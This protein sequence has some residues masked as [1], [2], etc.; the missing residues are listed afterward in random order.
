MSNQGRKNVGNAAAAAGRRVDQVETHGKQVHSQVGFRRT[1]YAV[2]GWY[3]DET[4]ASDRSKGLIVPNGD[5]DRVTDREIWIDW[6][7]SC[8]PQTFG[9][10]VYEVEWCGEH[11]DRGGTTLQLYRALR[12]MDATA[13]DFPSTATIVHA[14]SAARATIGEISIATT[15]VNDTNRIPLWRSHDFADLAGADLFY[16]V[17]AQHPYALTNTLALT[18]AWIQ[19]NAAGEAIT[20]LGMQAWMAMMSRSDGLAGTYADSNRFNAGY[21]AGIPILPSSSAG[22]GRGTPVAPA[23]NDLLICKTDPAADGTKRWE[24]ISS[25]DL[26]T[27]LGV[28][29]GGGGLSLGDP[30][31]ILRMNGDGDA[32]A[33]YS[34]GDL[35]YYDATAR[36]V[37]GAGLDDLGPTDLAI[38]HRLLLGPDDDLSYSSS[39]EWLARGSE[40]DASDKW[41]RILVVSNSVSFQDDGTEV[42]NWATSATGSARHFRFKVPIQV[43]NDTDYLEIAANVS[44]SVWFLRSNNQYYFTFSEASFGDERISCGV[45]FDLNAKKLFFNRGA[46]GSAYMIYNAGD[47]EIH[48]DIHSLANI[49]ADGEMNAGGGFSVGADAGLT[50]T[51]NYKDHSSANRHM[52][53]IGGI[54]TGDT[55]G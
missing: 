8:R 25:D 28:G 17:I 49:D 31:D 21:L 39:I 44:D 10:V 29:G 27:L 3:F 20:V 23:N 2:I 24:P 47:I 30:W 32:W 14:G 36:I 16:Q 19:Y 54:L 48:G 38:K 12:P 9:D 52:T 5:I 50:T 1:R 53:F 6:L 51:I 18:G 40:G 4:D 46:S 43:L 35:T 55:S 41:A 33:P 13:G 11:V 37:I 15:G 26:A 45:H 34:I 42:L 7:T 22:T